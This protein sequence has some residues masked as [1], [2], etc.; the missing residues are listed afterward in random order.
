MS[1]SR[2]KYFFGSIVLSF[3]ACKNPE[4][5]N[6]TVFSGI[7]KDTTIK[8]AKRFAISSGKNLTVVYLFGNRSN[9]DTTAT[10]II[11]SDSNAFINVPKGAHRVKSPCK[12][13]QL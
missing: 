5:K 3:L 9:Y 4:K 12:K 1:H 13:L 6:E 10:Y 7:K 11:Y 2:V 8:Y